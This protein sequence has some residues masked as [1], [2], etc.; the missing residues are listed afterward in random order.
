VSWR[1]VRTLLT[2]TMHPVMF[3]FW[4][5]GEMSECIVFGEESAES[6]ENISSGMPTQSVSIQ[7]PTIYH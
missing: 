2:C 5:V 3:I 7:W 6:I 4:V 1:S